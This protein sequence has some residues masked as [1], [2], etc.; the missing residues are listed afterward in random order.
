M[1]QAQERYNL[2]PRKPTGAPV[3]APLTEEERLALEEKQQQE[4]AKAAEEKAKK[5]REA[6]LK[7]QA[8][9]KRVQENLNALEGLF[10]KHFTGNMMENEAYLEEFYN[11]YKTY[12][13]MWVYPAWKK[14]LFECIEK[15]RGY[16]LLFYLS[17]ILKSPG[18]K[19]KPHAT[20]Q[21]I[22]FMTEILDETRNRKK[23]IL[24]WEKPFWKIIQE[25]HKEYQETTWWK[26]HMIHS[27][28]DETYMYQLCKSAWEFIDEEFLSTTIPMMSEHTMSYVIDAIYTKPSLEMYRFSGNQEQ[29]RMLLKLFPFPIQSILEK[30]P[31]S[32]ITSTILQRIPMYEEEEDIEYSSADKQRFGMFLYRLMIKKTTPTLTIRIEQ[33]NGWDELQYD[34]KELHMFILL[35]AVLVKEEKLEDPSNHILVRGLK[36]CFQL[37]EPNNAIWFIGLLDRICRPDYF[38]SLRGTLQE[39]Y[40]SKTSKLRGTEIMLLETLITFLVKIYNININNIYMRMNRLFAGTEEQQPKGMIQNPRLWLNKNIPVVAWAILHKNVKAA[41]YLVFE[42]G[43]KLDRCVIT[44]EDLLAGQKTEADKKLLQLFTLKD[45]TTRTV[46][47]YMKRKYSPSSEFFRTTHLPQL[48]AKGEALQQAKEGGRKRTSKKKTDKK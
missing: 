40:L 14:F 26:D 45:K 30:R 38:G 13:Y 7:K 21:T 39:T 42:L 1:S 34:R 4:A 41:Y 35:L 18:N 29:Q 6:F 44:M 2:R 24:L 37:K 17:S 46:R 27:I 16:I 33:Q 19:L 43:A 9:A 48:I 15:D 36:E 32:D 47:E 11:S 31:A 8:A 3:V 23:Y 20:I 10:Q 12:K 22:D 28:K 25:N 5:E